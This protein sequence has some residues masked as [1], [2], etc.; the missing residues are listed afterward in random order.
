MEQVT[1]ALA[2][3]KKP[4]G[5]R[6]ALEGE[7]YMTTR[8][9][10]AF[11][12]LDFT[13]DGRRFR[14]STETR[15][16]AD[17]VAYARL[18]RAAAWREVKLGEQPLRPMTLGEACDAYYRERSQGTAYGDGAQRFQMARMGRILCRGLLLER[19]DNAMVA[20][21]VQGLRSG[22]GASEGQ[23][24]RSCAS[25]ATVNRY[26]STLRMVCDRAASLHQAR[27]G[28]WTAAAHA[29]PEPEGRERFLEK[30]QAQAVLEAIVPHAHPAVLLDLLTG[31]RKG[32]LLGLRW[33]QVSLEQ[34]RLVVVQKGSRRHAVELVP[35][36][37]A[38]LR[39]LQPDPARRTGPVFVFNNPAVPCRCSQ[40][41]SPAKWGKPISSLRRSVQTAFERAGLPDGTRFHDF[42]HTLASWLLTETGNLR[43]VKETLGHSTITTTMRYAHLVG[44]EQG[45]GIAAATAGLLSDPSP[46]E[47]PL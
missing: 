31:L 19:L 6:K 29:M 28:S 40:C 18:R 11:W 20:R 35:Q 5:R 25:A 38:L 2:P 21:L 15:D 4:A 23:E 47:Q 37:V 33:E 46:T 27:V 16:F 42:R 26:L 12:W 45:R 7:E 41:S 22:Q 32:N 3:P 17:A 30:A 13:I 14:E 10:S 36:A 44:D 8:A 39:S 1:V 43:L 9:G 34:A 24:A